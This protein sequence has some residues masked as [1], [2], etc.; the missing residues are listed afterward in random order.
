MGRLKD[1]VVRVTP[2]AA[3]KNT[4]VSHVSAYADLTT[5]GYIVCGKRQRLMSVFLQTV[6]ETDEF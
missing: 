1:T 4:P 6:Q 5:A 2:V 3:S